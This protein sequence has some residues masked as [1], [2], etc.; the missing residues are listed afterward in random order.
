M[1][2]DLNRLVTNNKPMERA[3]NKRIIHHLLQQILINPMIIM[4][5]HLLNF[6]TIH[7]QT[8]TRRRGILCHSFE[9]DWFCQMGI[10]EFVCWVQKRVEFWFKVGFWWD[11]G[12]DSRKGVKGLSGKGEGVSG[13]RG[14]SG[15]HVLF[16]FCLST[17]VLTL[18]FGLH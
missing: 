11:S 8:R 13:A 18:L 1:S 10:E 12:D 9:F 2:T 16:L 17:F 7:S 3:P 6:P 5:L 4:G 14:I 15:T